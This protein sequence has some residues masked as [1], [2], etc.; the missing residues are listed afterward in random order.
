MRSSDDFWKECQMHA[1]NLDGGRH[2]VELGVL[3]SLSEKV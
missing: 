1:Y 3:D 2:T